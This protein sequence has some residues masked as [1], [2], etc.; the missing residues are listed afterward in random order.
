MKPERAMKLRRAG[1]A[2][3]IIG[4]LLVVLG[5]VIALIAGTGHHPFALL[6]IG[7][8]LA[9]VGFATARQRKGGRR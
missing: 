8:A 5:G 6:A 1:E 7:L 9:A 4:G 3:I 2:L